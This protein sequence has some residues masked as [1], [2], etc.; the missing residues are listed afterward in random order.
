[1]RK[2]FGGGGGGGGEGKI[3][4]YLTNNVFY[5][6]LWNLHVVK[7]CMEKLKFFFVTHNQ[8]YFACSNCVY[9]KK[10]KHQQTKKK[11]PKFVGM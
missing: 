10:I 3:K 2:E 6:Q 4:K 8:T 1:M 5:L 7:L 9:Y 11:V